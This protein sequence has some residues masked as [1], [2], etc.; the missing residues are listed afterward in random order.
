MTASVNLNE[1]EEFIFQGINQQRA[2]M[3]LPVLGDDS[4]LVSISNHWSSDL[5]SM[6]DLTHG[7]F[8]GRMRSIGLPDTEYSC[9]EIIASFQSG[10][11]NGIPDT[12]SSSEVAKKFVD[13]WLDSPPHREIMLTASNGYMGVGLSRNGSTFYGVVDFKFTDADSSANTVTPTN[14]PLNPI[15]PQESPFPQDLSWSSYNCTL[16][17]DLQYTIIITAKDGYSFDSW[18]YVTSTHWASTEITSVQLQSSLTVSGDVMDINAYFVPEGQSTKGTTASITLIPTTTIQLSLD[19]RD[20]TA[21][22]S[23]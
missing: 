18:R 14:P 15:Q 1:T 17:P 5:A 9:G 3:G 23:P 4:S 20:G 21:T 7:D 12:R 13:M 10:S 22:I 19:V 11:V 16:E 8:D 2:N 6:N